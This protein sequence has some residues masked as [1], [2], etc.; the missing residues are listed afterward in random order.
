MTTSINQ[1]TI[2]LTLMQKKCC[3]IYIPEY[4][5]I[6]HKIYCHKDLYFPQ[7][8]NVNYSVNKIMLS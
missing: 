7:N 5:K 1:V 8:V 3:T 2:I 4:G 6:C